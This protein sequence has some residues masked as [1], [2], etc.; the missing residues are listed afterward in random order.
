MRKALEHR[1]AFVTGAS[2]GIGL[3]LSK[4]LAKAGVEVGIAARR[5]DELR[6]LEREIAQGG[7]RARVYP[8]DVSDAEATTRTLERAD[9][10]MGGI[11]LV[12]ANAGVGHHRWSGKLS[13]RDCAP[14]LAVNVAGA[15]ATLTALLPRMVERKRGHLVGISSLAQYRGMPYGATYSASKAFLS[16]F[17]EGIRVD[18]RGTGVVVTDVRPGFVR[19]PMTAPSPFPMPFLMDLD[20][21]ARAIAE[22]IHKGA[23]IVAFPWQLA[24]VMRAGTLMPTGVWDRVAGNYRKSPNGGGQAKSP[25]GS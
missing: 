3:E 10:E 4:V 23:P 14:I 16:H 21:A 13:Y 19:T 18:L 7:G 20:R 12:V 22:G 25:K 15:V 9:Q 2:S 5:E 11:D 8:L 1:T 24:T 17:L 6:K